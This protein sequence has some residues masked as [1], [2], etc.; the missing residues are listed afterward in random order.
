MVLI[1][2]YN[3]LTSYL[4]IDYLFPDCCLPDDASQVKGIPKNSWVSGRLKPH[5]G[6]KK[7][8]EKKSFQTDNSELAV[9]Q[10]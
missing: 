8:E 9:L 7:E 1:K 5:Q 10:T 3:I 2:V 4:L 6:K